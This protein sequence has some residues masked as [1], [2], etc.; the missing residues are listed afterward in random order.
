M[1]MQLLQVLIATSSNVDYNFCKLTK[2]LNFLIQTP[3]VVSYNSF[4]IKVQGEIH[5]IKLLFKSAGTIIF[6]LSIQLALLN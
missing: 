1:L 2:L 3:A 5:L 4:N 6:Q